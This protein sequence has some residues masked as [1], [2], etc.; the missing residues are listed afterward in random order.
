MNV[1]Q[2]LTLSWYI[3]VIS[4][5]NILVIPLSIITCHSKL[6][7]LVHNYYHYHHPSVQLYMADAWSADQISFLLSSVVQHTT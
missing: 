7:I 2:F 3:F 6:I 5:P 4:E 1:T